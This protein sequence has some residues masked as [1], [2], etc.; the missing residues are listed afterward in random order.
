MLA[1]CVG[2]AFLIFV[3]NVYLS[4]MPVYTAL[5]ATLICLIFSVTML[6]VL[7]SICT[8]ISSCCIVHM[9]NKDGN[10]HYKIYLYIVSIK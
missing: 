8:S 5:H 4:G 2:V 3:Q 6:V 1:R 7:I 10:N 9:S